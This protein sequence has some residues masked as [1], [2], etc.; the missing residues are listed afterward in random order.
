[1]CGKQKI[2]ILIGTIIIIVESFIIGLFIRKMNEVNDDL[3][4]MTYGQTFYANI[5]SIKQYN[6]GSFH[7][8]VKGLEVNDI[9]YRGNFTFKVDDSMNMVW[10]GKKIKVSD[11]KEGTNI[12][13]TF[14]DEIIRSIS[15][16][17][18]EEVVK[19]Q[20]LDNEI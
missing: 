20:V 8:N 16:T 5:Q 19:I 1:M 7:L 10:R 15:P 4:I 18:L 13:I 12:S 3:A 6:D 2:F 9:N 11:L 17:P 14:T